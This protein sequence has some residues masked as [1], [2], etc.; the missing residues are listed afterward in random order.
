[1]RSS[2]PGLITLERPGRVQ[3]LREAPARLAT[4][5]RVLELALPGGLVPVRFQRRVAVPSARDPGPPRFRLFR[6]GG[7]FHR[8]LGTALRACGAVVGSSV[9]RISLHDM[10]VEGGLDDQA[11]QFQCAH[12]KS[13][14]PSVLISVLVV[15]R[16]SSSYVTRACSWTKR[17]PWSARFDD[18]RPGSTLSDP[19]RPWVDHGRP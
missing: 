18:G 2:C 10:G 4:C 15:L 16:A 1:M 12:Q 3:L 8:V 14:Q 9:Q 17:K 19:D 7:S 6:S 11:T 5:R 13:L